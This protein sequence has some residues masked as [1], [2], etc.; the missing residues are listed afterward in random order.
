MKMLTWLNLQ[1]EVHRTIYTW[2]ALFNA[3]HI[4]VGFILL[5]T[6]LLKGWYLLSVISLIV[7][8]IS[9]WIYIN[10]YNAA[11]NFKEELDLM[12]R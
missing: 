10:M 4:V 5:G 11:F 8:L 7:I 9:S 2:I 6:F 1:Y 12:E 3:A